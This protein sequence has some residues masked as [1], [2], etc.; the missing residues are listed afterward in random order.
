MAGY[1]FDAVDAAGRRA[2]GVLEA[3]G[4]RQARAQLRERGLVPV[5]VETLA[6]A[7]AEATGRRRGQRLSS[8]DLALVTRQ[9][10]TLLGAGLTIEETLSTCIEQSESAAA[11]RVLAGVRGEVRAGASLARAL[12]GWP[13]VFS[14]L[15]RTMVAAGEESGRLA[16]VLERLA[17]YIESRDALRRRVV[18]AFIYPVLVTLVSVL[19][20]TGLLTW[21]VPQVVS[22]FENS[23]Q[24]LP[25]LTAAMIG[26]SGFLRDYGLGLLLLAGLGLFLFRL[27]LR[28][29]TARLAWHRLLLRLP[30]LGRVIRALDTARLASTL[31]ILAG[32]GV[33]LLNAL[34]AAAGVVGNLPMRHAVEDIHK[35][36]REGGSLAGAIAHTRRFPPMMSH[37]V[38]SGEASG[39]LDAMLDRIAEQQTRELDSRVMTLTALLEPALILIMGGVV[40]TIVLAILLPIFEMNQLLR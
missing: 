22:V 25:V 33:P 30:V 13:G 14:E 8:T 40:L 39:R 7:G 4:P 38:A 9:L 36:V 35:R 3:D 19:V 16:G 1:R 37:L 17:D 6:E 24:R 20:V 10:A 32:S 12:A 2:S 5:S 29:E 27:A 31:A 28:E 11:Q 21:V 23:G 15:Y 34:R 18:A 26:L